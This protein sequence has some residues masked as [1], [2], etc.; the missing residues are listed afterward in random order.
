MTRPLRFPRSNHPTDVCWGVLITKLLIIHFSPVSRC[1]IRL[2]PRHL[3]QRHI[4]KKVH[5]RPT[6]FST[7]IT[8]QH[9]LQFCVIC[10]SYTEVANGKTKDSERNCSTHCLNSAPSD[11]A[12]WGVGLR[13]LAC[14][15]CGFESRRWHACLSVV[16]VVCRY[17]EVSASG[18]SLVQRSPNKCV[19]SE[20]DREDTMMRRPWPIGGFWVI[21]EKIPELITC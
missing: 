15:D 13:P 9:K 3:P 7:H 18:R 4:F 11:R 21:W 2:R 20:C 10:S 5:M 12:V 8:Q 17:V 6:K 19:V 14:W 1:F 16:S